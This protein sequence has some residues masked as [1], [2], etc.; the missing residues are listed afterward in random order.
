VYWP[1]FETN[2]SFIQTTGSVVLFG[3]EASRPANS[4]DASVILN[5]SLSVEM[6]KIADVS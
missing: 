4:Y 3:F 6:V 5:V 2:V 1:R